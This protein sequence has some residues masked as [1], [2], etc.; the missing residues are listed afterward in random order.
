MNISSDRLLDYVSSQVGSFFPDGNN[1]IIKS[2]GYLNSL[3][4]L[5]YCF[6]KIKLKYFNDK[7]VVKFDYLHGDQYSMFLYFLSNELYKEG[8]ERAAAKVFGLNKLMFGIDA[9]YTINLPDVF[10]FSHPIN[11]ILGNAVYNDYLVV[12]Q[13]VTVGSDLGKNGGAGVYPVIGEGGVLLSNASL[14]GKCNI[15]KNVI[16]GANSFLRNRDIDDNS[17]VLGQYPNNIVKDNGYV[18]KE[19]FFGEGS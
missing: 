4:R 8:N 15:G 10:Y 18:N 3:D 6:E 13:G 12:Y 2:E 19:Y 16:F 14:I 7:G 1:D 5:E 11:T 9:F 17:I